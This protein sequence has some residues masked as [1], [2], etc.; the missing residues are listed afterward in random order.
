MG[1]RIKK[2]KQ[3]INTRIE[4]RLLVEIIVSILLVLSSLF[5]FL[6]IGSEVL[7]NDLLHFDSAV[8]QFIY[9]F[10]S[11]N[12]TIF[13][14]FITFLGSPAF[15]VLTSVIM[16]IFIYSRRRKDAF[17]YL[18]IL[19]TGVILN[20]VL[21]LIFQR[22]RPTDLS[23]IHESTYSFPSGHSMNGLVFYLVL[24]YF[25]FR[26]TGNKKLSYAVLMISMFIVLLIGISRIYLGVHYPTD[27]IAGY[28][29]GFLWV[30]SAILF[31]KTIIYRRLRSDK[32]A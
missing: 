21:K 20:Y 15:L 26:E 17:I 12:M 31:E 14:K 11:E 28:I 25:V 18:G 24:S 7:G 1:K 3:T 23:L 4:S 32:N 16:I 8:T 2:A 9:A 30:T 27:V 13:M 29:A 10:R 22:P 6:K 19:V 5:L